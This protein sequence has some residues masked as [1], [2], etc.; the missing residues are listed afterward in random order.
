MEHIVEFV[1]KHPLLVAG[2]VF[3]AVLLI[4]DLIS[5]GFGQNHLDA[6]GATELINTQDAVV[7]DV[8]PNADFL[9]GHIIN[10]ENVPMS[11]LSG[12]IERL[13]KYQGRPIIVSCNSGG[14]STLACRQLKKAGFDP[15]YNLKGGMLAWQNDNFPVSRKRK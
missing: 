7:I 11:G 15:V 14:Q 2:F 6:K 3:L 8:R 4:Q 1:G 5:G 13:K 12:Q 10:A 9:K